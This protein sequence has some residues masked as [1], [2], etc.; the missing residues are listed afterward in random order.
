MEGQDWKARQQRSAAWVNEELRK[1]Q[2][3]RRWRA[4]VAYALLML[5]VLAVVVVIANQGRA[6]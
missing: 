1:M 6:K 2:R 4:A 5:G 3:R